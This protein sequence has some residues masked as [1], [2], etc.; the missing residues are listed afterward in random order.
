MK[1]LTI[2]YKASVRTPAGHRSVWVTATANRLSAKR[3][4]VVEVLT[5]DDEKVSSNMSR[6][7][8]NRQ[9]F[10]GEYLASQEAGK[11]KNISGLLKLNG[12]LINE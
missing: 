12:I 3:V 5:I 10:N 9:K 2:E 1:N 4:E 8:A 11:K 7:G 6:T